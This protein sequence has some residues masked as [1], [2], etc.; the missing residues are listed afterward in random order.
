MEK[1]GKIILVGAGP[2]NAG[3]LTLRGK[4]ALEEADVVLYDRL[5][6]DEILAMIPDRTIKLDVGKSSGKHVVPQDKINAMLLRFAMEGKQAVRLKGGDPYLFGR[7]AE[8][9]EAII[10][11][12]EKIPFEVVSG[13]TSA[14]AAPA[15]AGIPVSHR[16]FSSSVHIITAHRKDGQPPE[17]DY[18]SLVK[19]GGTLV[20]M[21]G[22]STIN[23]ITSGLLTAGLDA[24]TP[25]ALVENGTRSNQ[26]CIISTVA[27][28]S[29][30]SK[31]E[32]FSPPS[33]LVIGNVCSLAE[34]LDWTRQ[35]PLKGACIIVTRPKKYGTFSEKL[36]GLGANV[37]NYPCIRT[38]P[39]PI[40]DA[41]FQK[42]PDYGWIV[43]T[44][45]T[46]A[47]LFFESL[48]NRGMDIRQL[49]R[50]KYAAIGEKT[51]E[52]IKRHAICVDY[53]P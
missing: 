4:Q 21:M 8:E 51:S 3:L 45:Q 44:S 46:G 2:G 1:M 13:V 28:I 5:V 32:Q 20:F 7:G 24:S 25:A 22:L 39:L 12:K 35:L 30:R 14:I 36:R 27:E 17:I 47:E 52:V 18:Q 23:A 29:E 31:T 48:K 53:M 16:D 15:F 37:I 49:Y 38:V 41:V 40:P 9:L 10:A 19:L 33:I 43:F 6:S 42:L 50:V 26:R 34:K 11:A